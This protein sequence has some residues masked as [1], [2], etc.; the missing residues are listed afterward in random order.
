MRSDM[1]RWM[2]VLVAV[3]AVI[4][5]ATVLLAG[6][7]EFLIPGGILLAIILGYAGVERLLT[8]AHMRRHDGD[9]LEAMQDDEDWA[10][11]SAH[12]IPDDARPTGDTPEVHDEISP[13]DLPPDHPGR[14]AAEAQAGP[15]HET[16]GNERGGAGGRFT[17]RDDETTDRTGERERSTAAAKSSGGHGIPGATDDGDAAPGDRPG[18][19]FPL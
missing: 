18:Q 10:V 15:A 5:T 17:R 2:L 7:P 1:A 6:S 19:R 11:P 16:T 4:Y 8:R 9:V 3:V 12:L 14:E 13:H